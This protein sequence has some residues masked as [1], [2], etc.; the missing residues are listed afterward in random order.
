MTNTLKIIKEKTKY[1]AT[2]E[3]EFEKSVKL[4]PDENIEFKKRGVIFTGKLIL[5]NPGLIA[6]TNKRIIFLTHHFFGP[7]KLLYIPL[8]AISKMNFKTLGFLRSS[9]KAINLEYGNHSIMFGIGSIQQFMTGFGGPEETQLFSANAEKTNIE[10]IIDNL[11]KGIISEELKEIFDINEFSLSENATRRRK[12][13]DEWEIVDG[14][15]TYIVLNKEDKELR[16]Y[17]EK[18]TDIFELLKRNL[19]ESIIDVTVIPTT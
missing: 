11:N 4:L 16:I 12:E 3:K 15:D 18:I 17:E 5:Q 8:N 2:V 10:K 19:P 7:D 1:A 6:L 9:Q 13:K 14:E